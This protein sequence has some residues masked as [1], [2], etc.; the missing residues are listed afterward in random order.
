MCWWGGGAWHRR[1][2]RLWRS[3]LFVLLPRIR[4]TG[5]NVLPTCCPHRNREA[6][7]HPERAAKLS[8]KQEHALQ[9][10]NRLLSALT[11][12][13]TSGIRPRPKRAR[14][15]FGPGGSA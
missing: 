4:A 10:H 14:D 12:P 3:L 11:R 9:L 6:L 2:K 1:K 13:D 8:G 7:A 5:P 15:A